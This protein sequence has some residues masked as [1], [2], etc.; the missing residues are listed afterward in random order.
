MVCPVSFFFLFKFAQATFSFV[1]RFVFIPFSQDE[2]SE[3]EKEKI[4]K[5]GMIAIFA[6]H[7][8]LADSLAPAAPPS[9][10]QS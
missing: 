7:H 9:D 2:K 10:E 8:F 5:H 1:L 3:E 4:E 6:A